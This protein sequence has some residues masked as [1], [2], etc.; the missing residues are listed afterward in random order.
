MDK[1][2]LLLVFL[3]TCM[4]VAQGQSPSIK[5]LV[6]EE[7][8]ELN[9]YFYPSTLRM[10]N[11]EKNEEFNEL[12]KDIRKMT[13]LKL[14]RHS[15]DHTQFEKLIHTLLTEEELEEYI[16]IDGEKRK[17][18]VLGRES[19]ATT[20]GLVYFEKEYYAMDI[21]GKVNIQKLPK[22]YEQLSKKDAAFKNGFVDVF[23][24]MAL[25]RGN[26]FDD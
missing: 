20:I 10:I 11:L 5:K 14:D 23:N 3:L 26:T 24:V 12:I 9:L 22:L 4:H 18:Y 6:D 17:F 25:H 7:K 19:P 2:T 21:A 15:F 13:F 1:K 16:V 8:T